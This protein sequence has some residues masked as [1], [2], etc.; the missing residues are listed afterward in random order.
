MSLDVGTPTQPVASPDLSDARLGRREIGILAIA[1]V[2]GMLEFY[3]FVIFV[4]FAPVIGRLFF[5]PDL[6][7]WLRTTQALG[8]F[9]AGYLAR[10]LGGI[11][12]AHFGDKR[13]RKRTFLAGIV[14]MA[15]GTLAMGLTPTYATLG[16]AAP[17]LLLLFRMLQGA[18]IGGEGPG[19][20]VFVAEHA[21]PR[22]V[23][24]ACGLMNCGFV[25]GIALGSGVAAVVHASLSPAEV[26]L[27]GWRLPFILGGAFGVFGY[28]LRR[29]LSETPVFQAMQRNTATVRL[30][31]AEVL[32]AHAPAVAISVLLSWQIVVGVIA[33]LLVTPLVMQKNYGFGATDI[34][35]AGL[36]ASI[37]HALSSAV[38]GAAI[39]RFGARRVAAVGAVLSIVC[40][41]AFY[42]GV[43]A[44][45]G[46]F[47]PLF[48]LAAAALG[49]QTGL[50]P[51]MLVRSYPPLVR[52][53]GVSVS[54]NI[55]YAVLGGVTPPI[56]ASLART[57]LG[58]AHYVAAVLVAGTA[59]TFIQLARSAARADS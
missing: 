26:D 4:F 47:L 51:Y 56:V 33:V 34:L 6:P 22:R 52:F 14:L 50:T 36:V 46:L 38:A 29:W 32:R 23:G 2:G 30:P 7:D 17:L 42:G 37:A 43:A 15:V 16:Y 45:H 58:P 19:A 12:M 49:V 11:I 3:D 1:S 24:F 25:L 48:A 20:W 10:P 40:T 31:V 5:P 39:D 35:V 9:A 44:N 57:T 28:R 54:Y 21:P 53:S 13:G 41:Y 27:W 18:A 55:T 59:A 8:I